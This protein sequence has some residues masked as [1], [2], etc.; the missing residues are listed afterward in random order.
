MILTG[1]SNKPI[2]VKLSKNF[3]IVCNCNFSEDLCINIVSNVICK[4]SIALVILNI[5]FN[6]KFPFV[7]GT[8]NNILWKSL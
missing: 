1:A 6:L 8:V 3:I 2:M 7:C 5:K 4:T